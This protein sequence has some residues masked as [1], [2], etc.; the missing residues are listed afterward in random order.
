MAD[1]DHL[2]SGLLDVAAEQRRVFHGKYRATV[3]DNNDP[4]NTGRIQVKV[5][6]IGDDRQT[7]WAL[8][9]VPYA[10]AGH[11]FFI[12]PEV[13]D[14]VWVEFVAGDP[15]HPVWTGAY[16]VDGKAP[17][18]KPRQKQFE[19]AG[20]QHILLDDSDGAMQI[21]IK[22]GNGNTITMNATG[23]LLKRGGMK[24]QITNESVSIND[25]ALTVMA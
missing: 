16:W 12:L 20:G 13:K 14:T 9:C 19:T 21:E 3:T 24:I 8:P 5:P 11:G 18:L 7:W 4:E 2:E 23:I 10:S 15:S 25:G 6:L 22:D 1:L 17:A